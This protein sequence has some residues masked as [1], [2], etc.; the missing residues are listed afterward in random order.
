MRI[1]GF[2][3][4]S[5]MYLPTFAMLVST[6]GGMLATAGWMVCCIGYVTLVGACWGGGCADDDPDATG[7]GATCIDPVGAGVGSWCSS[8]CRYGFSC[9]ASYSHSSAPA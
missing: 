9:D 8:C 5:A 2:D 1:T 4:C 7:T 6:S 3:S